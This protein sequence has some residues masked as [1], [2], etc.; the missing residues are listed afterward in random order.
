M[1]LGV[2]GRWRGISPALL[3]VGELLRSR[4]ISVSA[5]TCGFGDMMEGAGIVGA[6]VG[7]VR[8]RNGIDCVGLG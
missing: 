1:C 5:A 4:N 7:N 8:G 2:R 6:F 3:R